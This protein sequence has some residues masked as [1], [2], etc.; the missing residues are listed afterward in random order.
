MTFLMPK[1]P[2]TEILA[3]FWMQFQYQKIE[4]V[5]TILPS[6]NQGGLVCLSPLYYFLPNNDSIRLRNNAFERT[7]P[8]VKNQLISGLL[9]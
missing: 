7:F 6:K 3:A 9:S 2:K 1:Y 4:Q 5:D 8:V